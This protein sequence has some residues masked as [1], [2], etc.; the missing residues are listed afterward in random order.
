MRSASIPSSSN[1]RRFIRYVF[2]IAL[3]PATLLAFPHTLSAAPT[4]ALR[5]SDYPQGAK[6]AVFPAT[7][8]EADARFRRVHRSSF[9]RLHRLDGLGWLQAAIWHFQLG[10]GSARQRHMV[11]FGYAINVFD[12]AQNAKRAMHDVRLHVKPYRVAKIPALRYVASDGHVSLDFIFFAY[13]SVEIESYVEYTGP[14]PAKLAHTLHHFFSRQD[15]HLA[16]LGRALNTALHTKPTPTPTDT[17]TPSPTATLTP[18]PTATSA[19]TATPSPTATL[20]PTATPPPTSTPAPTPTATPAGLML[21]VSTGQPTY[22]VGDNAV[23][24]GRVTYNGQPVPDS[25]IYVTVPF[26]GHPAT[27]MATTDA[28]G[29]ASCSVSVPAET[30]GIQ[31]SVWVQVETPAG[32][33]IFDSSTS[34]TIS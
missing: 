7:N 22:A 18:V 33:S 13:G 28:S 2:V 21:Q 31:V 20:V 32:A 3:F 30:K 24:T 4:L 9:E 5:R 1:R 12:S 27:C 26:P 17:P 23:I 15:S 29:S 14:A 25:R 6:I 34:V 19:P 11:T 10:R 8:A 16:Q